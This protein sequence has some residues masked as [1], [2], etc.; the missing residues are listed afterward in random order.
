VV[1][2][3]SGRVECPGASRLETQMIVAAAALTELADYLRQIRGS[4]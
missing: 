1:A 4:G 3:R 2:Q